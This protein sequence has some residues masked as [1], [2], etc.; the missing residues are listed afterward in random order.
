MSSPRYTVVVACH[1]QERFV[2]ETI[3]SVLAQTLVDR[4][5][6]VVDDG[7]TDRS[8]EILAR[9]RDRIR[10]VRQENRGVASAWNAGIRAAGG[11][12][13]AFLAADDAWKPEALERIDAAFEAHPE[14]GLVAI[15]AEGMDVGGRPTGKRY[16]KTTPGPWYSTVS[17]LS[18]DSGGASWF[19]VRRSALDRVGHYDESLRSAEECDL[20]LRLSFAT[21]LLAVREPLLRYRIHAGS[22]SRDRRTNARCWLRILAKLEAEHPAFVRDHPR[23]FRR[24]VGKEW[25]RLGR[26]ILA[27][28]DPGRATWDEARGALR[29]SIRN[30]PWSRRAWTYLAWSAV[31]P[32]SYRSW[33]RREEERRLA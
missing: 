17:L 23:V 5:I 19:A 15:A 33:R 27:H 20:L 28:G 32:S 26:E 9:Y 21:R 13:I 2:A 25:L 10:I 29:E 11:E 14:A 16:G 4:E 31:W 18:G 12:R 30:W 3:E 8:P 1:D 6:V 24:A 7:S 22:L